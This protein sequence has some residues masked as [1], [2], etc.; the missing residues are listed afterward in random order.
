MVT[1]SAEQ[2]I[3]SKVERVLRRR[4]SE[5]MWRLARDTGWYQDAVLVDSGAASN[6]LA[7]VIRAAELSF[8]HPAEEKL[9]PRATSGAARSVALGQL[10]ALM[11]ARRP[12]VESIRRHIARARVEMPV[13]LDGFDAYFREVARLVDTGECLLT[14]EEVPGW[15]AGEH[16]SALRLPLGA[17]VAEEVAAIRA[18]RDSGRRACTLTYV[19][20]GAARVLTVVE[21]SVLYDLAGAAEGLVERYRC[22]VEAATMFVLTGDAPRVPRWSATVGVRYG[23]TAAT[24]RVTLE[25][26][27]DMS[28][29]E[30]LAA[31]RAARDHLRGT[32]KRI[33]P[34]S[35]RALVLAAWVAGRP[36]G[37]TW[38]QRRR[39]WN[40]EHGKWQ[41]PG[42][43]TNFARDATD[44][45]RRLLRP[46][47]APKDGS[48]HGSQRE[49]T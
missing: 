11:A 30:V 9:G 36:E 38:E 16:Y 48:Q 24:T 12:D 10:Y 47:W 23:D 21:S 25:L 35:E 42:P 33:R 17:N 20:D 2:R 31:Y 3:R 8:S 44:A 40:V 19:V 32:R 46:G 34:Q 28:E 22:N 18:V 43:D 13:E 4:V 1:T 14:T 26:D 49:P 29:P 37:E 39:A 27:P 15:V 5:G 45:R 6:A 41:H 7:D